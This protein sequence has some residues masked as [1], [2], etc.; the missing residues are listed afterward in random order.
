[1]KILLVN[2]AECPE[3]LHFEQAFVRALNNC[4]GARLDIIHDFQFPYS[5]IEKLS[6][7]GGLRVKYSAQA[8][9]K[10][11][12]SGRY[13]MLVVLDFPKR[14]ACAAPF[15]RLLRDLPCAKKVFIANHLIPMPGQNPTADIAGKLGLFSVL[16]T[17]YIL[18]FDDPHLWT[19]LGFSGGRILKRGYAVDCAYYTPEEVRPAGSVFSAGSAGRDFSG[20]ARAVKKTGLAL[21]IFS[22]AAVPAFTS[23]PR[24]PASVFPLAKNLHN[25]R[26]AVR[27]ASAVVIPIADGHVNEAAGNS[28]AFIAMACGRPVIIKKTPYMERFIQD[29]ENGFLYKSL[30]APNLLFQL[31]RAL[32]LGPAASRRL[33]ES[34]RASVLEKASLD[35]FTAAFAGEFVLKK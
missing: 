28:I 29:G 9:L 10:R 30:S 4:K 23:D 13:D 22:D 25:L 20:L 16:D 32:S 19:R 24:T 6:P 8:G 11:E 35:A 3:N 33:A 34:A 18:E 27:E 14:K 21:N 1:M 2:F 5:F 15:L 12:L 26:A 17:A 31:R 7:P